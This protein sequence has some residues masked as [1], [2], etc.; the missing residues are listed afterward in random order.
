MISIEQQA[1]LLMAHRA[2]LAYLVQA[3]RSLAPGEGERELRDATMQMLHNSIE[4]HSAAFPEPL[5]SR[6][7]AIAGQE[8]DAIMTAHLGDLAPRRPD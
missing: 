4:L 3:V 1:G 5:R 7:E 8:I 2:I 6:L